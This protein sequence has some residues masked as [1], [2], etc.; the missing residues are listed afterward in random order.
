[1][2]PP[3][4]SYLSEV[5]PLTFLAQLPDD[6]VNE[7]LATGRHV[8]VPAGSMLKHS[9]VRPGL[10]IVVD[11]LVRS[12]LRSSPGRQVTVRYSRPGDTLGLVQVMRGKLDV[13]AQAVTRVALW[14]L[15]PRR[16]RERALQSA[17][18]AMAIAED[19]AARVADAVEE[20]TSVAFGTVR[21]RVARHLLDLAIA[22]GHARGLVAAVTPQELADATGSVREV[23][24]RVLKELDAARVT[25]R[26]L[27]G[28][29]I[30]DAARLDADARG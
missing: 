3:V 18:L 28:I 17:A 23:V 29:A 1:V 24:A 14:A 16:L 27:E 9:R 10:A 25:R 8:D 20:L 26:S 22:D 5:I 6:L 2:A 13:N 7:I 12:Y 11:G 21:Q 19:C 15:S 4:P 30:L